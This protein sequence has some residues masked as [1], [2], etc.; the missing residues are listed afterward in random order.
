MQGSGQHAGDTG[1]QPRE[2]R[3][4]GPL[5]QGALPS[6]PSSSLAVASGGHVTSAAVLFWKPSVE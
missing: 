6:Q 1:D 2:G 4:I 3:L 5:R